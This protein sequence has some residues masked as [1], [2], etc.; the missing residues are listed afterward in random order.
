M[1]G[2]IINAAAI[3]FGGVAGLTAKKQ[4]PLAHQTALKILLGAFTVYVGLSAAWQGLHGGFLQIL[5]Q[6]GI[7][8]L[9]LMLGNLTG[10][11]LRIQKS[12]NRLGQYAKQEISEATADNRSRF[13]EGFITGSILFCLTPIAVLGSLQDGLG[14]NFKPLAA[15]AVMDGLA[16]MAFVSAFGWGVTVAVIPVVAW[17]GTISLL[18]GLARPWLEKYS[19]SDPINATAGLLVFCVALIIFELKKIELA[20]YLPSLIYAP[21]LTW[22]WR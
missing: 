5:K 7:V 4:L 18:A 17:Q 8:L 2:T 22:M 21:L 16:T 12:L 13:S 14:D 9:S 20:D 11:L 3:L 10:K 19:L 1:V 15:K 6:L